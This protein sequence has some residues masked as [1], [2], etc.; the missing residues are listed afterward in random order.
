[1]FLITGHVG[2]PDYKGLALSSWDEIKTMASSG[3]ATVGMHTHNLHFLEQNGSAPFLNPD[4]IDV[5]AADLNLSMAALEKELGY[6][7]G[8]FSYPYG[9]GIPETDD[10]L[11]SAGIRLIFSSRAGIVQRE[12]PSFFIKRVS[13]NSKTWPAVAR[14]AKQ[15]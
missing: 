15:H 7:P 11:M 8:Y 12:D 5:F 1:L 3:L 10:L 9:F 2:N 14:W 4:N 13:V 6:K